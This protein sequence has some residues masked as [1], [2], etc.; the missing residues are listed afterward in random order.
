MSQA[1]HNPLTPD[2]IVEGVAAAPVSRR[3]AIST[4]RGLP[5]Y[6]ELSKPRITRLVTLTSGVGF[7]MAAIGQVWTTASLLI[8]GV[9]ALL[10]TATSAAGANSLNQWM[11]RSRDARMPRTMHRPLPS[12]RVTPAGAFAWG[13]AM[14]VLGVAILWLL[15][16]LVPA[17]VSLATI[18]SYLLIYTPLKPIT[19]LNTLVGAVPGALPPLIGWTA[20]Q[21]PALVGELDAVSRLLGGVGAALF[22]IMLVWQ[23]PHFL[24]IAWMYRDD[25]AKGGYRM[26]PIVDPTGATTSWTMLMWAIALLPTTLA[27]AILMPDRI[28]IAYTGVALVTGIAF[29][30]LAAR[31]AMRRTRSAARSVFLAS[32]AHLPLLLLVLVADAAV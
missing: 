28:G 32:I 26:L 31:S 20:A 22:L 15:C 3:H 4:A 27:P 29:V 25:Y 12:G 5:A 21:P 16:G 10:G 2:A 24:A 17:M 14:C 23:I 18:L 7:A 8:V 19:T 1:L 6:I 30:A 11:E 13:V 9:G